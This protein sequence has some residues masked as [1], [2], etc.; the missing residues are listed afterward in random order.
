MYIGM[1]LTIPPPTDTYELYSIIN[2]KVE[3][4]KRYIEPGRW[5][6]NLI[7]NNI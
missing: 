4:H 5:E 7:Y 2:I 1:D 6:N 3:T